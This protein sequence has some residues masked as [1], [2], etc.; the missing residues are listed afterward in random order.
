MKSIF[1]P[2]LVTPYKYE[3][4]V[5]FKLDQAGRILSRE[6]NISQEDLDSDTLHFSPEVIALPGLV[7]AHSHGF[8]RLL[9]GP[10]QYRDRAKTRF[11]PGD[12]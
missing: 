10:T 5:Q 3:K 7:N 12:G 11:G 2:K 8:Q 1:I 6:S 4:N 9:R